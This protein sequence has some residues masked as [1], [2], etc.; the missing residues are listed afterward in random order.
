MPAHLV[1]GQQLAGA[2]V[3][4]FSNRVL[5]CVDQRPDRHDADRMAFFRRPCRRHVINDDP[6][7][8]HCRL[9]GHRFAGFRVDVSARAV[10]DDAF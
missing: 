9:Y 3:H 2:S 4:R 6:A 1:H 8:V 5:L 7:V 10:V